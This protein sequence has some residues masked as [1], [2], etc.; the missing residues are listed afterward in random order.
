MDLAHW[1]VLSLA[2]GILAAGTVVF[3]SIIPISAAAICLIAVAWLVRKNND[4]AVWLLAAACFFAGMARALQG[5][6]LPVDDISSYIGKTVAVYGVVDGTPEAARLDADSV[7][8]RYRLRVQA[9]KA[10]NTP[11]SASGKLFASVRQSSDRPIYPHGANIVLAGAIKE[12]HGYNNPGSPDMVAS[13]RRQGF[14]ARL[15]PNGEPRYASQ[16]E[17]DWRSRLNS[18]R[19]AMIAKMKAAMPESDAAIL[20]GALF[21]GYSGIPTD[22][23]REFAATGI[24]HILSVSGSHIALVAGAVHWLGGVAGLRQQPSALLAA[25]AVLSY[26]LL[27]G[28]S[29]PVIRSVIMGLIALS[30]AVWGREKDAAN[31]LALTAGGMLL[32]EPSLIEDISFQLS[33]SGTAGLVLL[34]A[35]TAERLAFLPD[36]L[37]RPIAATAAAQLGVLPVM[38]W[39]FNTIP[40]MSFAANLLVVPAIELTVV[41]GLAGSL[42][43]LV[44]PPVGH[45]LLVICSLILST[46]K[47]VNS[48]LALLP[49]AVYLPPLN[50]LMSAAYYYCILW[51]YGYLTFLPDLAF[52]LRRR[53]Q[54]TLAVMA[55]LTILTAVGAVWP[56]PLSVHFIDVGQGDATLVMTPRGRAVLI[57]TG[58]SS[59]G[60]FDIGE[61][62]V[63]PYLRRL[64]VTSLDYLILT[65]GHQDHAGGAKA[66]AAAVP[67]SQILLPPEELTPAVD[68]LNSLKG[69][70][71]IPAYS[72]QSIV[73]DGVRFSLLRP[74]VSVSSS[75]RGNSNENSCVVEVRYG[76]HSFLITGD[77]EG[78]SEQALLAQ[79]IAPQTVLKVGHHGAQAS[80]SPAFLTTLDPR[81]AVI[82]VGAGNRYGHPHPDTLKRL[83]AGGRPVFR[84]DKHGAVVFESD[85]LHLTVKPY[86]NN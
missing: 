81:Y 65:H 27:A 20:K 19:E 13:W 1:C 39:Y 10:G 44:V 4:R 33:F 42:T 50:L 9:V 53:R 30:A 25:F 11:Q 7:S 83:S 61:R 77:L 8:V 57:D 59:G 3:S 37:S 17:T 73:I 26:A 76:S 70:T 75:K 23:I 45:L 28:L 74:H 79:G 67:V 63:Y 38:A 64:H 47:H 5:Q 29:P 6:I 80:T 78:Q 40:L 2:V 34:Y 48:A 18:L 69:L 66:V 52:L 35:K 21:G 41:L 12:L 85:G 36:W 82:S 71:V 31:A 86:I 62:V 32:F 55:L 43:S 68:N 72:G 51:L 54:Q 46:A 58:G 15:S 49:F 16:T 14:T 22:A 56:R 84:T 24:I 60:D